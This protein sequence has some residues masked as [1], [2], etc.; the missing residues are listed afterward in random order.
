MGP[1]TLITGLLLVYGL[2]WH[3]QVLLGWLG[4]QLGPKGPPSI[5]IWNWIAV[6]GTVCYIRLVERRSL[7]S[8]G[9]RLPSAADILWAIALWPAG[10]MFTSLVHSF[11]PPPPSPGLDVMMSLSIPVLLGVVVTASLTEEVVFRG[12]L[13]E[14]LRELTGTLWGG[15]AISLVLFVIPHVAFFG[16]SWLVYHSYT[17]F[18]IYGLYLWR[19]NLWSCMVLH[20]LS[21]LLILIPALGLA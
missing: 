3:L 4:L 16:A 13:V 1:S 12:Y 7:D 8:I 10:M 21:N 11:V 15:A 9:L 14:R 5:M 18:L 19:R 20:L 6:I 2:L 17:T